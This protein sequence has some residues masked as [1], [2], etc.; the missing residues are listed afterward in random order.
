MAEFRLQ[1]KQKAQ[2]STQQIISSQ[3]LQL[4]LANL[5]QRI[6]EELQENPLL[7]A[8]EA[9]KENSL[10]ERERS[11]A[12]SSGQSSGEHF[13]Q[14]VQFD[15][16]HEI[17]L[18]QLAL[19]ENIERGEVEVAIEILGNLDSDGYF[20]EDPEVIVDS[21]R[22]AGLEVDGDEVE[23]IRLKILHLDPP[24]WRRL[25]SGNGCLCSCI[26]REEKPQ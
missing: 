8:V 20:V 11:S 21:L 17:L 14:A 9:E 10:D 26:S 2:L 5:E 12:S 19:Q 1:Q 7:D 23:A 13:F 16:F 25:I 24:V 4:P 6:Y 22:I 18:K 3:L 15:S